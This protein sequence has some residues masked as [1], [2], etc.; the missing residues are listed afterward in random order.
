MLEIKVEKNN[1]TEEI[2]I[3]NGI[4]K[5]VIVPQQGGRIVE[6]SKDG[7]NVFYRNKDFIGIAG[8]PEAEETAENWKNFGGYKGWHGPQSLWGWPPVFE[9]DMADFSYYIEKS[10]DKVI[11]TL[12]APESSKLGFRSVRTIIINDNSNELGLK[13]EFINTSGKEEY[14]SVWDNTQVITPGTAEITLHSDR[15]LNGVSFFHNFPFPTEDAYALSDAGDDKVI[16]IKCENK[17]KFKIGVLTDKCE[18]SYLCRAYDKT[19]KY[20]KKFNY[21]GLCV[22]PHGNNI[23]LYSDNALTYAELEVL[24]SMKSFGEG[25][26]ISLQEIWSL[27]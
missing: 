5:A 18:I 1:E 22:Y 14:I 15:F 19:I 13:E 7:C 23:E 8:A 3:D 20:T 12:K 26:S 21:E 9:M 24:T 17:E 27:E 16:S 6:F 11:V 4:I 2:I 25:E 10:D